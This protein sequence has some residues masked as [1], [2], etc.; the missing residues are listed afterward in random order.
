MILSWLAADNDP[1]SVKHR[2]SWIHPI[3]SC[4]VHYIISAAT[5]IYVHDFIILPLLLS[6]N[7]SNGNDLDDSR[8]GCSDSWSSERDWCAKVSLIYVLIL[9]ITRLTTNDKGVHRLS[10]LYEFTWLCNS[11][12][13]FGSF[14]LLTCRPLIAAGFAVAVSIDQILWW[15]DVLYFIISGF[16][17][18]PIGVCKY[19]FWPQTQW[20]T[21]ITCTHHFWTIP[22]LLYGCGGV[23]MIGS[24][25]FN[26]L[27][28]LLHVLLSRFLTPFKL[29]LNDDSKEIKYLNVNLCKSNYCL[30]FRREKL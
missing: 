10:V 12:L 14:A 21:K 6:S 26:V 9:L 27:I 8:L 11:A 17:T 4:F 25:S 3:V 7:Q 20:A 15:V 24:Y 1:L 19:I 5:I 2:G 29:S 13:V 28:V 22:L 30:I 23:H 18:F 16:K